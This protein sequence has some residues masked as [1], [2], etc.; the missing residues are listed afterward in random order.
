MLADLD[1]VDW[2]SMEHAYGPAVDVPDFLRGLAHPDPVVREEALDAMYGA[3][4]HQY[5]VYECTLAAVPFLL[6]VLTTPGTPG[7]AEVCEL[8]ASIC[9]WDQWPLDVLSDPEI[10]VDDELLGLV[11][12]IERA[13]TLVTAS[14]PALRELLADPDP[15]LR[16]A[17][18]RLLTVTGTGAEL[19]DLLLRR[20]AV[21]TA[22]GV[23]RALV[24]ALGRT[25]SSTGDV[26]G[27]DVLGALLDVAAT[28]PVASAAVAALVA[29]ARVDPARVPL[30]GVLGLL[31]RA[32]AEVSERPRAAGFTTHTLIGA[33]RVMDEESAA[34]RR[35]P[36]AARLVDG[37][38][39]ALGAR[40][41]ERTALLG[42]VLGSPHDDLVVDA[43]YGT[44]ALVEGWRGRH[45]DLVLRVAALLGSPSARVV[46]HAVE[47]LQRCGPLAGP[48]AD[49]VA[50]AVASLD[51]QPRHDDGLPRWAPADAFGLHPLL[52]ALAELG[53]ERAVPYLLTA[54]GLPS[55]PRD[56][57]YA[58]ARY[59]Q[60]ADRIV[61]AV[62]EAWPRRRALR[63]RPPVEHGLLAALSACGAAAA[64]AVPRLLRGPL[65]A[66]SAATL[67]AIGPGAAAAVPALEAAATGDDPHLAV[68]AAAALGRIQGPVAALPLLVAQVDGPAG[69]AAL[70]EVGALGPAASA[71]VPSLVA[72]L[73]APDPHR[74]RPAR[75]A[76]ALWQVTGDAARAVPVLTEAWEVN[77][78]TRPVI[79]AA[80]TGALASALS[81]WLI[82][83]LA[84]PRRHGRPSG[85]GTGTRTSSGAI[86]VDERLV[87]ACRRA[88]DDV[89]GPPH[90]AG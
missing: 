25:A 43:L 32:Y 4:H 8:L 7:R 69:V 50:E 80:A 54:L 84:E 76:L 1:A 52:R 38:T 65:D 21:E 53:D 16:A 30:D 68:V 78:R 87:A 45:E 86:E 88:L 3:V 79:A 57:G 27:A 33:I 2:A 6:E 41:P 70:T 9:A 81:P 64:P 61:P 82:A 85:A 35:A 23:A 12:R 83:E 42:A 71:A 14:A 74:W 62:L 56:A 90:L 46:G 10:E 34:S 58:L 26:A 48:A 13:R 40:V 77:H 20:L 51:A 60:H 31:E 66:G 55:R 37:L 73:D 89:G 28:T 5:D 49:A 18:P 47:A 39:D 36:H 59:P 17:V 22:P 24:D 29:V 19:A 11:R 44:S 67:G 72:S 63:A 15:A 75:A